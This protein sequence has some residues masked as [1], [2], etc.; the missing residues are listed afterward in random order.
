MKKIK[1]MIVDDSEV[2]H[3]ILAE[4]FKSDPELEVVAN[5][6]N[7]REA[8]AKVEEYKPDIIIMDVQMP[9][10]DGFAATEHIM[11]YHPTPI[12]I[13]SSTIDHDEKYSSF[14]AISLGALDV[15][16]KPNLQE[17]TFES[18]SRK[19][20]NRVK[21]LSRIKVISHIRGKLK[22]V[23]TEDKK[24]EQG[25]LNQK[26][27]AGYEIVGIGSSTGGPSAL[28]RLLSFFPAD[29]PL[30]LVAVQHISRG[31][32]S[33]FCEWLQT[34][35]RIRVKVAEDKELLK[36]ATIYFAP[37]DVQ[38]KVSADKK[39]QLFPDLPAWG[40]HKPSVNYLFQS[41]AE[42]FGQRVIA[43]I[44]TGM[45]DDGVAGMEKIFSAGGLTIA[46]SQE[47][48]LIFGMPRAA[49]EKKVVQIIASLE[50]IYAEIRKY[51]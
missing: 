27:L 13:F 45:G 21:M 23:K 16:S 34:K 29:F 50:N 1:I 46:Q 37:D 4:I 24:L 32:I 19:I 38:L 12:L 8:I 51:V 11:A 22:P 44:M 31:F 41:L 48:C 9:E 3:S 25:I 5:A 33:S 18:L 49:I 10:L 30:P 40:E 2:V 15:M 36:P 6:Y 26:S 47:S 7:G 42:N 35:C 20:I 17:E 14:Q 28:E 43:I 39:I